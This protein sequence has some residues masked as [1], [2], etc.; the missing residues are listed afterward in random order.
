[1]RRGEWRTLETFWNV[2][3]TIFFKG[4]AGAQIKVRF[5]GGFVGFDRQ[6]QTLD[7]PTVKKLSVSKLSLLVARVQIRTQND[8]DVTYAVEPGDVAQLSP[9]VQF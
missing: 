2:T 1:M 8:T 9:E 7:S 6:R 4:P 3:D 5:S